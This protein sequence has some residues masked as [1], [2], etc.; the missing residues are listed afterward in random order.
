MQETVLFARRFVDLPIAFKD[1]FHRL[2]AK[3]G[4]SVFIHH[5]LVV[6]GAR[7]CSP[8]FFADADIRKL[9]DVHS[10]TG[11]VAQDTVELLFERFLL[12][13]LAPPGGI[14]CAVTVQSARADLGDEKG[15]PSA[16]RLFLHPGVKIAEIF[17]DGRIVIPLGVDVV[18]YDIRK[19]KAEIGLELAACKGGGPRLIK[20]TDEAKLR[21]VALLSV[22]AVA[23]AFIEDPPDVDGGMVVVI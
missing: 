20:C 13:F 11:R 12:V 15:L 14:G 7:A 17:P 16:V 6:H 4:P 18:G 8:P 19:P 10:R 9:P 3:L 21:P 23:C 2:I 5:A 1:S 22:F